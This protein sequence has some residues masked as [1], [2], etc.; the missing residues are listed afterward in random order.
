M[1]KSLLSVNYIFCAF[2]SS[3][4]STQLRVLGF[5]ALQIAHLCAFAG[6][7]FYKSYQSNRGNMRHKLKVFLSS[8]QHQDEFAIERES[9]PVIF[10]KEPLSS[11]FQLWKI[12]DQSSPLDVKTHYKSNVKDSNILILLLCKTL[13]PA[14]KEE[15]ITAISNGIEVF[16]FIKDSDVREPELST[17]IS[18]EIYSRVNACNY[19]NFQELSTK[20]EDS[21]LGYFFKKE[22]PSTFQSQTIGTNKEILCVN[23][24]ERALRLLIGI[25]NSD[26]SEITK[27]E[28][29]DSLIRETLFNSSRNLSE[30]EII[31]EI[32]N[33]L[34]TS[35]P[36]VI[37][38]NLSN[39]IIKNKITKISKEYSLTGN[40]KSTISKSIAALNEAEERMF[41]TLFTSHK[42]TLIGIELYQYK[43]IVRD[44][45]TSII[46][47][48]AL[49]MSEVSFQGDKN[50][51]AYDSAELNSLAAK[52]IATC[53]LIESNVGVW[54]SVIVNI[55]SS[56]DVN[57]I[58][59]IN[60]QR[61][62][63][64]LLTTLGIDPTCATYKKDY[65][66]NYCL[67]LDSH[68]VIRAIVKAGSE[69]KMC[70]DIISIS[71]ELKIELRLS[72]SI[73]E[74]VK[75]TFS[76]AEKIYQ[77]SNGDVL[78]AIDILKTIGRRS[79]IFE[80]YLNA[81]DNAPN[82]TWSSFLNKFYSP[83]NPDK[84]KNYIHKEAGI[85]VEKDE[86]FDNEQ[87]GRIQAISQLLLK[88]RGQVLSAN[89][90]N[91][92]LRD[93]EARQMAIIYELRSK[94]QPLKQYW[95][96]TFDTF[97]YEASVEL[98]NC[99][100]NFYSFPCYM[101]PARLLEILSTTD[102][103]LNVN[104][105]REVLL[106]ST[107]QRAADM[108][109][110]EV[111]SQM[112]KSRI[113]QDI[114]DVD[115]LRYMFA[116]IINQ[117]AIQDAYQEVLKSKGASTIVSANKMKDQIIYALKEDLDETKKE[118]TTTRQELTKEKKRTRYYK[119]MASGAKK[120][121]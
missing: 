66:Q 28:I 67:Y 76:S 16:A 112:L 34:K 96:I 115:T 7:G 70:Q 99:G 20:I 110:A 22:R 2:T 114:K 19:K 68:I 21:I 117:P 43:I 52:A 49:S 45:I 79:D 74:E 33:V 101:K 86:N 77:S 31:H 90:K 54:Q 35:F 85:I 89:S 93:N 78:R 41:T 32:T 56:N 58:R 38:K 83:I 4:S 97:V 26:S 25:I 10:S 55:L 80:G 84:L 13:R 63:Y 39:L 3:L 61:K 98:A 65:F 69:S 36:I 1:G 116:D 64:W 71:R 42:F 11:S 17:F 87:T 108:L 82:L 102:N 27:E 6:V 100:D 119:T 111:I 120:K 91:Q 103:T 121:K 50:P 57:V 92:I 48:T 106:S 9:L 24:E 62:S 40:E 73:F 75:K 72:A 60:K 18:K 105:Y 47:D 95:F 37:N 81:K 51:V 53:S 15:F 118:L 107:I 59:W 14:V 5:Q 46:Y 109:E 104:I 94:P 30:D 29:Y 23:D 8:A 113:D 12:E 88:K 44:I